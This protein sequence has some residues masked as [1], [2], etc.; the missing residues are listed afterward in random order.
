MTSKS[1]NSFTTG[2]KVDEESKVTSAALARMEFIVHHWKR[3]LSAG[4]TESLENKKRLLKTLRD[5][6]DII[7]KRIENRPQKRYSFLSYLFQR[8][9]STSSGTLMPG[10]WKD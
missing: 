6:I 4:V 8:Q 2:Q 7:E 3:D 5:N 1:T 9:S 10:T